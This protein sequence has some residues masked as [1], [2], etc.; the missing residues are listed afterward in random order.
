MNLLL[1]GA[2]GNIGSHVL[3][4]LLARG[5]R[6]RCLALDTPEDRRRARGFAGWTRC[7][8]TSGTPRWSR[9]PS[10][11]SRWCCTWRR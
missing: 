5:H 9:R 4:E 8:A 6:V 10:R 2:F 11:A 7:G 1:T 3:A